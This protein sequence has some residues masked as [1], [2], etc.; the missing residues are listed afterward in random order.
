MQRLSAA[1]L[2]CS[3]NKTATVINSQRGPSACLEH[4]SGL[5][6]IIRHPTPPPRSHSCTCKSPLSHPST[7]IVVVV[8][9]QHRAPLLGTALA[10]ILLTLASPSSTSIVLY[11][12]STVYCPLFFPAGCCTRDRPPR[13]IERERHTHR[14]GKEG[15]E[16]EKHR[17]KREE[18]RQRKRTIERQGS[19]ESRPPSVSP[20]PPPPPPPLHRTAPHRYKSAERQVPSAPPISTRRLPLHPPPSTAP[21]D[22]VTA[23]A[24]VFRQLISSKVNRNNDSHHVHADPPYVRL[25]PR[26]VGKGALCSVTVRKLRREQGQERQAR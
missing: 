18:E 24:R 11:P 26:R 23:S 21:V 7:L 8:C 3:C 20:P 12:L 6:V 9:L 22:R 14:E 17:E 16:R 25:R 2:C 19:R 5:C 4:L 13:E 15:K 1:F 10:R